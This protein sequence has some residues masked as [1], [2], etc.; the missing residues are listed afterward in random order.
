MLPAKSKLIVNHGN[1]RMMFVTVTSSCV[2]S[3]IKKR[4]I[5]KFYFYHETVDDLPHILFC[6]SFHTIGHHLLALKRDFL[7]LASLKYHKI[8]KE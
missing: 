4:N 1:K 2:R 5:L 3:F 6:Y 8:Q 7:S